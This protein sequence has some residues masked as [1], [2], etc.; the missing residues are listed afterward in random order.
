LAGTA[1]PIKVLIVTAHPD[2][3]SEMAAVTYRIGKELGGTVDQVIVSDG[4]A[5]YRYS[6]LAE[7]VYGMHLTEESVGRSALP[8]IRR[9]EALNAGRIL[10]IRHHY[11]LNQKDT[12]NT[13][14]PSDVM[15]GTWNLQT[16]R[17]FL[18]KIIRSERYDFVFTLLP[19]AETHGQHQ[20]ATF[21]T[22]EAV[23]G[24]PSALRPVVLGVATSTST[25]PI[26]TF[27]ARGDYSISRTLSERPAYSFDRDVHFGFH[28]ALSYEIIV[29]WVI[30]E[31]KSQGLFQTEVGKQRWENYWVFAT[32][33]ADSADLASALFR[34]LGSA[35][36]PAQHFRFASSRP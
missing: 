26:P 31:H 36:L 29:N 16:V 6:L 28:D 34:N 17:T 24:L 35:N 1:A 18:T 8:A 21:L 7:R 23:S 3:E 20:A 33:R 30:A 9:R 27:R 12:Q 14:N 11:F 25:S 15:Q 32:G 22:L 2:D 13:K 4:E 5:G 19:T 10:G